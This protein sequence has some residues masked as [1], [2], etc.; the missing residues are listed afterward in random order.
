M[1]I[2]IALAKGQQR[3]PPTISTRI[4]G[5]MGLVAPEVTNGIDAKCRIQNSKDTPHPGE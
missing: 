1:I 4:E 2:V 3:Y 5:A